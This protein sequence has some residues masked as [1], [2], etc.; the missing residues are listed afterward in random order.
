MSDFNIN[1]YEY[2]ITFDIP[3]KY[4]P[5][6]IK[7]E[8]TQILNEIKKQDEKNQLILSEKLK[9]LLTKKILIY[10]VTIK[11]YFK[12]YKSIKCLL[13]DKDKIPDPKIISM[14]YLDFLMNMIDNDKKEGLIYAVMLS[15]LFKIC[16]HIKNEDIKKDEYKSNHY[17]MYIKNVEINKMDFNNIRKIICYQNMPDYD[18]KYINP[19][20]KAE[21]DEIR[22]LQNKNIENPSLE[23]QMIAVCRN[24]PYK[25]N[26][27]E[28]LTIRKFVVMLSQADKELHYK[29]YKTGEIGGMVKFKQPID[30]WLYESKK[31]IIAENITSFDAFKQKMSQVTK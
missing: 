29:I 15:E 18:D 4:I 25:L 20:I 21:M 1:Q 23:K 2:Q 7:D 13:I 12:F 16:C 14:S 24:Y 26:E 6:K 22:E 28:N 27:I 8:M 9:K 17:K 3:I 30:H 11:N 19:D 31:D 5:I 10:P